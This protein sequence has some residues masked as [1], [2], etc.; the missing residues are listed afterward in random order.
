[1]ETIMLGLGIV[2]M[3]VGFL[4][5]FISRIPGALISFAGILTLKF[6]ASIPF[7]TE[8]LV[9]V[10]VVTAIATVLTR[11]IPTI[12]S[13]IHEIGKAG[14]WGSIIGSIGGLMV[15]A[16]A[17]AELNVT[18]GILIF[19]TSFI[20]LPFGF[21]FLFELISKKDLKEAFLTGLA[22]YVSYLLGALLNL[23]I[24]C[25]GVYAAFTN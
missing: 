2:L 11:Y 4:G 17:Q 14:K 20:L 3:A 1:M 24:C 16:S 15:I 5:C 19:G 18:S 8:A 21:S 13:H 12:V 10:G 7:S 22:S 23:A 9:I 6:G 25:Y